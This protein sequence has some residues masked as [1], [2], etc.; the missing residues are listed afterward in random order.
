MQCKLYP[1]PHGTS[2][3]GAIGANRPL[4]FARDTA[5]PGHGWLTWESLRGSRPVGHASSMQVGGT[6]APAGG[7]ASLPFVELYLIGNLMPCPSLE[8]R[9][10][11]AHNCTEAASVTAVLPGRTFVDGVKRKHE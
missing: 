6:A 1:S 2:A 3:I 7:G 9:Y 5:R 11:I 8:C 10:G 4:C